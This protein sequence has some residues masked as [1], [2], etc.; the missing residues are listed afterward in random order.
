MS[1]PFKLVLFAHGSPDQRWQKAFANLLY[2]ARQKVGHQQVELAYMEMCAP[3][4]M[5]VAQSAHEAGTRKLV[6][7][8]LFM[9]S[10]GHVDRDIPLQAAR[11]TAA[12]DGLEVEILPPVGEHLQ[13]IKVLLSVIQDVCNDSC[14]VVSG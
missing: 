2:L 10:G 6:V 1:T 12:C 3:S 8:P 11:A 7:L 13:V 9:A 5:E 4:L 14:T